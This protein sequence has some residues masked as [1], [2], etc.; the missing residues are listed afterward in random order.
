MKNERK[1]ERV[2]CI[3]EVGLGGVGEEALRELRVDG[4]ALLG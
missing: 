4:E 3:V 1:D 2:L